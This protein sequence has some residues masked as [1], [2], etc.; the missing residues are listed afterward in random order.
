MVLFQFH[1]PFQNVKKQTSLEILMT[2]SVF[3]FFRLQV[4]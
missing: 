1:L 2:N 4:R 3:F